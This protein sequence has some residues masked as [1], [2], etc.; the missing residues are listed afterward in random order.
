MV[1]AQGN[2]DNI[3]NVGEPAGPD[4]RQKVTGVNECRCKDCALL[5]LTVLK[6]VLPRFQINTNTNILITQQQCFKSLPIITRAW[7]GVT[8]VLTLT[9]NFGFLSPYYYV[10]KW[11]NIV[12]KFEVWR[13]ATC[14]CYAGGFDFN[15]LIAMYTLV[16]F[17]KNYETGGPFNT[18]AGGTYAGGE[19]KKRRS[20]IDWGIFG[21]FLFLLLVVVE[22]YQYWTCD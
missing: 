2:N 10:F 7:F 22:S 11:Q 4:V 21:S 18:G 13:V 14:F 16:T 15:T 9:G 17:S 19:R 20:T 8:M 12:S 6:I 5:I 3:Q 1:F